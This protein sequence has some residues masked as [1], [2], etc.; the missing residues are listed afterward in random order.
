[1]SQAWNNYKQT[2]SGLHPDEEI[3]LREEYAIYRA[4]CNDINSTKG[5]QP[6][7]PMSFDEWWRFEADNAREYI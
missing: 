7:F 3:I 2:L 1:M 5:R 4:G 6:V